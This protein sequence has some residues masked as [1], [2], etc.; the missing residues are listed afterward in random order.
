MELIS[1]FSTH[2]ARRRPRR[3]TLAHPALRPPRQLPRRQPRPLGQIPL[4]D[5]PPE[6]GI[7]GADRPRPERPPA[8]RDLPQ[9]GSGRHLGRGVRARPGQRLRGPSAGGATRAG[10]GVDGGVCGG[11]GVGGREAE[12]EAG[13]EAG[14]GRAAEGVFLGAGED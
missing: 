12:A 1:M 13:G 4:R 9:A 5:E 14:D 11:G 10:G 6:H 8:Q 3:P 7:C 2:T